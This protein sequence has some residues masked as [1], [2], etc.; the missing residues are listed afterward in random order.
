MAR[1]YSNDL[2]RKFFQA[3]DAADDSLAELGERFQ[4]SV[5]LGQEEFGAAHRQRR[6]GGSDPAPGRTGK[7]GDGGGTGMVAG[8][9]WRPT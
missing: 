9:D 8:A 6:G 7:S 3:Y 5:G 1:S 2:R 4:V